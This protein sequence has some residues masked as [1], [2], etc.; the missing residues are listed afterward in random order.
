MQQL[1]SYGWN[2]FHEENLATNTNKDLST[3]RVI[4]IKG[5]KYFVMTQTGE[6]ETE[7]S[8][9]LLYG[10]G[11][12][13]LPKVGD[14]VKFKEYDS[15]GYLIEVLPRMNELSRKTPGKQMERQILA[16][17]IDKALI[18]QGLD[19]DFNVMRLDRYLVQLAACTVQAVVI[20]NKSDLITNHEDFRNEIL[21]LKHDCE[22]Y[23]CSTATGQGME[24]LQNELL[25]PGSTYVL[26]GSS[27]VG[28][29]SLLNYLLTD[30]FQKIAS[31]S[32]S[33]N[34]GK[35][36]TTTRDLFL[37]PNGSLMIDTPGMREFG[38]TMEDGQSEDTMFPA[39]QEFASGC[40]FSNCKHI[41]EVGCNVLAALESGKLPA[42]VYESYLKLIKEQR[43]FG[44]SAEDKKRQNK[45]SGKIS[46]EA[47]EH[48]RE[49]KF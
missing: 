27:G 1:H 4:S 29:S 21:R 36:T 3:G 26:I 39:I 12:E 30:T 49:T 25:K 16:T 44:I 2:N 19:R 7:L 35:H 28:K 41:N 8:G 42:D 40:R 31:V 48:R 20:L 37:L 33:N 47:N 18:V 13:E 10:A 32:D 5:F 23:F 14:W 17:N 45:Q 11:S 46:R 24:S 43:R 34:K 22:I 9:K 6:I 15:M 38:V